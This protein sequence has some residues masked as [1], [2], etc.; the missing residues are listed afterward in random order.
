MA[1]VNSRS[2]SATLIS[3]IIVNFNGERFIK[4]C[5]DS[6]LKTN[7]PNFEII[8][9]DNNSKDNS[10]K[11][12]EGFSVDPRVKIVLLK[13]NLQYAG[14]NNVGIKSSKGEYV[15]F[16][17]FDTV[18]NQNW[19]TELNRTF[20][21]NERISAV[22]SLLF[23]SEGKKFDSL[24]GTIDYCVKL[25]PAVHLWSRNEAAKKELRLFYGCGAALAVRRNV[26][27]RTGFFDPDLPTDEVDLCWRINLSGGHIVL[28]P[29]S[30][31]FHFRSGAFGKK[32]SKQRV[33]FAELAASSAILKNY[34]LRNVIS[35]LPYFAFFFMAAAGF[36]VLVRHDPSI[37]LFRLKAYVQVLQNLR[38]ILQ[39]RFQVQRYIRRVP[40]VELRGL[41]IR[42]NLAYLLDTMNS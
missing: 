32:L 34:E 22:Q 15:V 29:K 38:K 3:V 11:I 17:N 30:I 18:V 7:Y 4:D 28:A 26:L 24:G 19:L 14:G 23:R 10:A 20:E 25:I 39:K 35:V 9:V 5:L 12:L 16:L 27:E 21:L 2:T 1:M 40:D 36:D 37:I 33:F 42:P 13:K 41:M 8:V 31:V 6:V